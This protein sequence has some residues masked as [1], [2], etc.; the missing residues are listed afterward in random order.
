MTLPVIPAR[1]QPTR[2]SSIGSMQTRDVAQR[3]P[4]PYN[5]RCGCGMSFGRHLKGLIDQKD[6]YLYIDH[7]D[8]ASNVEEA[9]I[10][11]N[12]GGCVHEPLRDRSNCSCVTSLSLFAA[13]K[14]PISLIKN[15][16]MSGGSPDQARCELSTSQ[17]AA[18]IPL[19]G[20][21]TVLAVLHIAPNDAATF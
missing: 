18:R 17:D 2:V 7:G 16:Q 11:E 20:C 4:H 15:C 5:L 12:C 8:R 3:I 21:R 13:C 6:A 19:T 1:A 10:P 9:K 14:S